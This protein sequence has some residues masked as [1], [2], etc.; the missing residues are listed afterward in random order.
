VSHKLPPAIREG[1][2]AGFVSALLSGAPS[3]A[4][5]LVAGRDPLEAIKAAGSILLPDEEDTIKLIGAA[6]T[7]HVALSLA[8]GIVLAAALPRRNTWAWGAA[9]GV[10]IAAL[11]LGLIG[12]ASPRIAALP[13]APQLADHLAYGALTGYVLHRARREH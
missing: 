10:V 6:L 11:D 7:I 8:W 1:L 12:R 3:T 9:A 13:S 2:V 4:H 5:A